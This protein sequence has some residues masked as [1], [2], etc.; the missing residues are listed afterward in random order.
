MVKRKSRRN[1][2]KEKSNKE[3]IVDF[4]KVLALLMPLLVYILFIVF[5]TPAPNSGFIYMGVV[6]SF[7]LGLGLINAIGLLD[8]TYLGHIITAIPLGLGALLILISSL[9]MY[10]PPI[11]SKI[12]THYVS[13]YFL[14]WSLLP[15]SL[16]WY[17][18]FRKS[19]SLYLRGKGISR[20]SINKESK[21]MQNY[22]W[23]ESIQKNHGLG[24]I[25][26]LNKSFTILYLS[27]VTVHL[28]LGWWKIISPI[29]ALSESCLL[30][31]NVPMWGLSVSVQ[32]LI[33]TP[34]RKVSGA[35]SILGFL[36]PAAGSIAVIV[37]FFKM[38]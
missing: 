19:I 32:G 27:V 5:I 7:L 10:I 34:E 22:W 17:M 36:L 21:G 38:W 4:L 30:I 25:Y 16:I 35:Y 33:R 14:V 12:D 3:C 1:N 11:Y 15:I 37:Y 29:V 13:F 31:L 23:Y 8:K 24:W 26:Y 18:F 20:T 28:L 2:I 6:G 9:I